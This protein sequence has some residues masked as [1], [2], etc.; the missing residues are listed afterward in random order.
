MYEPPTTAGGRESP[1]ELRRRDYLRSA[2]GLGAV[3]LV[4][5]S[6]AHRSKAVVTRSGSGPAR[7]EDFLWVHERN[8]RDERARANAFAF[9]RRH[10]LAVVIPVR[11]AEFDAV[12]EPFRRTMREATAADL[13]VWI[14][15][16]LL[17]E[18]TAPEFVED[19]DARRAHLD[20]L[21]RVCRVYD[22]LTDDG[23]VVLWEEAP[24]MGQWVEGGAWN[25]RATRNMTDHGPRIFDEQRRAVEDVVTDRDVG[26]FV[27]FPY[28]VDSKSPDVF[29][30]LVDGI[31]DR[32][33]RPDFA[34]L[35]FYR[36][37]YEKDV[38]PDR[39]DATVRSLITNA[40]EALRGNPV[41]YLGQ[42]HTI[43]PNH[44]PSKQSIRSNLRASLDA[45]AS[46]LGWYSRTRYLP[47]KRGFD[48]FVPNEPGASFEDRVETATVAR[49]RYLY[50]W[51]S[52]L[53]T[54]PRFDAGARFDCWLW[55]DGLSFGAHRL[56][57]RGSDGWTFLR[58]LD[59]YAD[60]DYP[61]DGGPD[62]NVAVVR[63][64]RRDRWLADGT[65]ELRVETRSDA[66]EATLRAALAMPCDPDAYVTEFEG[67]TLL[68]GD[69]PVERYAL[70]ATADAVPLVPGERQRVVVPVERSSPP[71]LHGLANPD[72]L[73][74][75]CRLQSAERRTGATPDDRFDLWIR[76][77]NLS[78][79]TAGPSI[80]DRRGN[81]FPPAAAAVVAR[82]T[83]AAALYY[84][85]DRDRFLAD[86]LSLADD[87]RR[88]TTV[89]A[90]YAMPYAGSATFR[91]PSAAAA[92]FDEQPGEVE[93]YS[94]ASVERERR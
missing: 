37:W 6:L 71:S 32:G 39:A 17:T 80:V 65:L 13:D 21:R 2:A 90:A 61:Y 33:A 79:P 16:G 59:G 72:S 3:G 42:A 20:R 24:V 87:A 19:G 60:G 45:G 73:P 15:V 58:D 31:T 18:V 4:D 78:D 25:D 93:T 57:V 69:A 26:I 29:P 68:A 62:G 63:A 50:A 70:G 40:S 84:G 83:D 86:G 51:L 27:H 14:R 5:G 11:T 85:L 53:A 9:A 43:N 41:F 82:G 46:G 35:D 34:F 1:T 28:V 64:L 7:R 48:P 10:D 76:G 89:E 38:G 81:P 23:R 74:A 44:T 56:S 36:G 67:A 47:T 22:R 30:T 88:G 75:V 12:A 52:T 91:P 49:D 54:R 66:T 55:A 94:I 92:L 77:R 8:W